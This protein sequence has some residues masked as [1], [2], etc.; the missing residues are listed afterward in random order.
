MS[1]VSRSKNRTPSTPR[2]PKSDHQAAKPVQIDDQLRRRR[3]DAMAF[4]PGLAVGST[5]NLPSKRDPFPLQI[6]NFSR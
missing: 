2:V 4:L 5:G 1:L 3:L 6:N